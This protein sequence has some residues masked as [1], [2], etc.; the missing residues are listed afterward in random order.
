MAYEILGTDISERAVAQARDGVYG[1]YSLRHLK[2]ELREQ[3]FVPAGSDAY[4]LKPEIHRKV[5]LQSF[6]L[7]EPKGYAGVGRFD[8]I[9]CR[10]VL[11]YFDQ[12]TRTQVVDCCVRALEPGGY[13][14]LAPTESLSAKHPE[15]ELVHLSRTIAYRRREVGEAA[16]NK[17][18]PLRT[19]SG[20]RRLA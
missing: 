6:N 9:F 5:A 19:S 13:L 15:L 11:I 7:A 16:T 18:G 8:V 4:R 12:A 1:A 17:S 10:N 14:L 2:T 20:A 3:Y